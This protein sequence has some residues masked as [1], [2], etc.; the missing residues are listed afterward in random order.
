MFGF[1]TSIF[2]NKKY[3]FGKDV[4]QEIFMELSIRNCTLK[5]LAK[6]Q[7]SHRNF[8]ANILLCL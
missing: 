1:D 4:H 7:S 2:N 3:D 8:V 5:K 6:P